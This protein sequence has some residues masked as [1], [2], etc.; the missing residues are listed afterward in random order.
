MTAL[1]WSMSIRATDSGLRVLMAREISAAASLSQVPALSSPV[2]VSIRDLARS[3]AC[4][5]NRRA[6]STVGT[7]KMASTGWTATTTVIRMPRSI[8]TKSACSASR[9]SATSVRRAAGSESFTAMASRTRC[10][11]PTISQA[12]TAAV[13]VSACTPTPITFPAK[14]AGMARN[15]SDATPYIRPIAAAVNT[16][17]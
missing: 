10:R 1:K 15:T 3:C 11:P 4:I 2:L 6:S 17:R 5:I 16:R 9:F 12:A 13:Q 14:D 8:C 7:A